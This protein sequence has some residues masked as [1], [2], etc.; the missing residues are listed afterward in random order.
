[1]RCDK[2]PSLD[3][4]PT[5][6]RPTILGKRQSGDFW[7]E[8]RARADVSLLSETSLFKDGFDVTSEPARSAS[9]TLAPAAA[10]RLSKQRLVDDSDALR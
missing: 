2:P 10:V 7:R 1:M 4:G 8:F 3:H 5:G 6:S 9:V